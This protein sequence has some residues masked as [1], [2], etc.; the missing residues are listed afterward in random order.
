MKLRSLYMIWTN[1]YK[2][3]RITLKLF[4]TKIVRQGDKWVEQDMFALKISICE[5]W[6]KPR[7]LFLQRRSSVLVTISR[8]MEWR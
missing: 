5:R 2:Y 6:K 8:I 1:T 7:R 3:L 4:I